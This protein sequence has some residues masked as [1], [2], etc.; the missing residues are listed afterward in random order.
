MSKNANVDAG[1]SMERAAGHM[2]NNVFGDHWGWARKIGEGRKEDTGD[3]INDVDPKL[4]VQ[5]KKTS[6]STF[7]S[8]VRNA[9]TGALDQCINAGGTCHI[10]LTKVPNARSEPKWLISALDWPVPLD[11]YPDVPVV[12]SALRSFEYLRSG[13]PVVLMV[14]KGND[15]MVL[16][17]VGHFHQVYLSV[18]PGTL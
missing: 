8:G 2:L 18:F 13:A 17:T 1:K 10:G 5:V 16:S 3:L 11:S 12:S 4:I 9:A 7:S 6:A 14:R 15:D